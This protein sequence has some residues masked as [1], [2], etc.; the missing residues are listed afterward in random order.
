MKKSIQRIK[1]NTKNDQVE[2]LLLDLASF[3]SI[4]NFV[5]EF[6]ELQLPLHILVH[7]AGVFGIPYTITEDGVE[8]SVCIIDD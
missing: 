7:N 6:K 8:M 2:G 4:K 5:E 3:D 1:E